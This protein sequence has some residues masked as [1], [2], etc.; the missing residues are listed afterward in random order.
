MNAASPISASAGHTDPRFRAGNFIVS[1]RYINTIA[2]VDRTSNKIVWKMTGTTVGQHNPHFIP[3]S[4]R[5]QAT[6]RCLIT[7]T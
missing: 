4:N 7:G 1:Y 6:F 5:V 3:A 2:V